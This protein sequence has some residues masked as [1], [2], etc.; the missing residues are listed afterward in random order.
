[1][2]FFIQ[3]FRG[4]NTAPDFEDY[5]PEC[6]NAYPI[7]DDTTESIEELCEY[8]GMA[9]EYDVTTDKEGS[10]IIARIRMKK[11]GRP[12]WKPCLTPDTY[13]RLETQQATLF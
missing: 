13:Y 12:G 3:L 6:Y 2:Q 11:K 7:P 4:G 10:S 8:W 1:M 9:G 5:G